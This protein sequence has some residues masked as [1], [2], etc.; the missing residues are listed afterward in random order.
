[1]HTER[2][3]FEI[4]IYR[5]SEPAFWT[6]YKASLK[7]YMEKLR[8]KSGVA[9]HQAPQ[10]ARNA[11]LHFW[12]EYVAPWRYNQVVGWVH[13]FVLGEQIRGDLWMVE[14][15][16]FG[17]RMKLKKFRQLG[18]AFEMLTF[19]DQSN[20]ELARRIRNRLLQV[21]E[22]LGRKKFILDTEAFDNLSPYVDWRKLVGYSEGPDASP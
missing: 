10:S 9:L 2:Y 19:R 22:D 8:C 15:K 11:E 12:D 6:E 4:A 1:M 13:T 7:E 21:A 5:Q 17:R 18:K 3:I 20:E 14:A 16:R